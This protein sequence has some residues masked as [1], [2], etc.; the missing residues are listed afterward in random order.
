MPACLGL[1]LV[2]V[3]LSSAVG[4]T[5]FLLLVPAGTCLILRAVLML[6]CREE[7]LA[8]LATLE[9][10]GVGGRLGLYREH[11]PGALMLVV[12][13]IGWCGIGVSVAF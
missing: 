13:G 10:N 2:A 11:V 8:P 9:R 4:E 1:G 7:V 3:L 5:A 12:I 6:L